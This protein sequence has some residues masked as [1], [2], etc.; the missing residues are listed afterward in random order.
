VLV[1]VTVALGIADLVGSVTTPVTSPEV[2]D[3]DLAAAAEASSTITPKAKLYFD[4]VQICMCPSL[5]AWAS[6]HVTNYLT[7]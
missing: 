2:I 7:C 4:F 3:C 5:Y 1:K 6:K